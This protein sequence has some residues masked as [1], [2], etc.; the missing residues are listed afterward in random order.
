MIQRECASPP[1]SISALT[2]MSK[3][4]P[5]EASKRWFEEAWRPS[6]SLSRE[7]NSI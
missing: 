7:A 1:P 5:R 3:R 2:G 4:L 6:G